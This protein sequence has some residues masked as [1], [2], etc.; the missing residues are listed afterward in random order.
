MGKWIRHEDRLI[1]NVFGPDA[2]CVNEVVAL[3][4]ALGYGAIV[5][6]LDQGLDWEWTH[7]TGLMIAVF[8][9]IFT[10]ITIQVSG[11]P[12]FQW[13]SLLVRHSNRMFALT[14]IYG[15]TLS[16]LPGTS[17]RLL[18]Q[19]KYPRS[20]PWVVIWGCN[21]QAHVGFLSLYF[22]FLH[23][24]LTLLIFGSEYFSFMFRGNR[25]TM[26]WDDEASM[27]TAVL[28]TSLFIITGIASLPS[29]SHAMNKV[30]FAIIFGK[31][32]WCALALGTAHV[33]FLG[34]SSWTAEPRNPYVWT[35]G[36]PPT[37]LLA[38][39]FP[40][41]A[42]FIKT[43]QVCTSWIAAAKKPKHHV[44]IAPNDGSNH[45]FQTEDDIA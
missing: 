33:M 26:N 31:V 39:V 43:L 30:Q 18:K 23:A 5:L 14:A 42:I 41:F 8:L 13:T 38:S 10:Y 29:V 17:R 32:V 36:M 16:L 6:P 11:Q 15:F 22:L 24:C 20:I 34:V 44:T 7:A 2:N 3:A 45:F 40:L 25:G 28:S 9:L 12:N 1:T 35:R 37:T 27:L 4:Q 19:M 21:V